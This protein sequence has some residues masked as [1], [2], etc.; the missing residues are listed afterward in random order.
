MD[1][2][3]ARSTVRSFGRRVRTY[4]VAAQMLQKELGRRAR[5][6]GKFIGEIE[7]GESNPSLLTMALV[8]DALNCTLVDLL[9][10]DRPRRASA[11]VDR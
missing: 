8:A 5:V 2:H 3:T 10:T 4:R 6:S 1:L 7:R 9:A 11:R